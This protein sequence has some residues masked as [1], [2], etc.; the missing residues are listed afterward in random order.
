MTSRQYASWRALLHAIVATLAAVLALV[1]P[2]ITTSAEAAPAAGN[3]VGASRPVMILYVGSSGAVC[4]GGGRGEAGPRPGFVSGA[5]VA[6]EDG[7]DTLLSA[8]GSS[9]RLPMNMD[10][11]NSVA[12]K[13]GID[14]S[15]NDISIN[16][17]TPDFAGARPRM[18]RSRC[19]AGRL[20]MRSS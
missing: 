10:T 11:V 13:Y 20:R 16:N 8:G 4:A 7:G 5:C 2:A 1:L 12:D 17:S 18:V 19:T 15:D 14:V 6:A 9:A 3:A